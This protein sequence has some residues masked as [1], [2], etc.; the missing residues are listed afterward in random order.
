[1]FKSI[2]EGILSGDLKSVS[3]AISIVERN[4][5]D[6]DKLFSLIFPHIKNKAHKVGVTGPPGAGKSTLVNCLIN[7]ARSDGLSVAAIGVD[8]SS[9][10]TGGAILGDRIR[11]QG[12]VVDKN[13]FIRSMASR[14]NVGGVSDS[15]NKVGMILDA[16]GYDLILF[17]TVGVGQL[18]VKIMEISDTVLVVLV[19]ESGDSIQM[20]KAGLL[21]ISDIFV[22]NKSDRPGANKICTSLKN[23][24]GDGSSKNKWSPEVS[25]TEAVKNNGI[26]EL[27]EM[28][29][30]HKEFLSSTKNKDIESTH[31]YKRYIEELLIR[32][33][34]NMFW[35]SSRQEIL[36][37]ELEK[38]QSD[39]MPPYDLFKQLSQNE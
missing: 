33:F 10:F 37:K 13:V 25:M 9:P 36:N 20:M 16:A 15:T 34:T 4:D 32:D 1:M 30:R 28:I 19:P 35:N 11:M 23:L 12:H 17:E 29:A 31:H 5:S 27:F 8:P 39:R 21:E 14:K 38:K 22:V 3:K 18:E 2:I 7:R 26:D 6:S 24:I